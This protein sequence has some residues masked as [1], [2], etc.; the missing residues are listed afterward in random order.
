ME[1]QN[2]SGIEDRVGRKEGVSVDQNIGS[3]QKKAVHFVQLFSTN[4]NPMNI[5]KINSLVFYL[6]AIYLS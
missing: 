3:G 5:S 4:Y 2:R 1:T 6:V